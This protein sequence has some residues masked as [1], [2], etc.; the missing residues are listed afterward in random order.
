MQAS[1][2][3]SE[4]P[5]SASSLGFGASA[6]GKTPTHI[7]IAD[8]LKIGISLAEKAP[9][10]DAYHRQAMAIYGGD[11]IKYPGECSGVVRCQ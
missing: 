1:F 4:V 9:V 3:T 8:G 6:H 7:V 5:T 11:K 2:E 10:T